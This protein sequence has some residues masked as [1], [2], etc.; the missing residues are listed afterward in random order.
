[1]NFGL[2]LELSLNSVNVMT[3][4]LQPQQTCE[5]VS[6]LPLGVQHK[7]LVTSE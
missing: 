3:Q 7:L 4:Y 5:T 1:M 2:C 6:P